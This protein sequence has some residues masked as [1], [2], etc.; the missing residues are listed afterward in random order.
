MAVVV[1]GLLLLPVLLIIIGFDLVPLMALTG[2]SR[3]VWI[4][5]LVVLAVALLAA[6]TYVA[7]TRRKA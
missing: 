3:T 6:V 2:G 7:R 1:G 4:V 5:T